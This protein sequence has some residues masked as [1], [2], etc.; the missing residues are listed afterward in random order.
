MGA[1]QIAALILQYGIPFTEYLITLIQNKTEVTPAEWAQLKALAGV[2]GRSELVSRLQ[3]NGIDPAS[4]QGSAL[5]ALVSAS[6]TTV[7]ATV[8]PTEIP[9]P[10]V[11]SPS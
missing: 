11:V 3:A 1:A 4:P 10:V 9:P 2:S 5:L 7:A 6:P 8:P